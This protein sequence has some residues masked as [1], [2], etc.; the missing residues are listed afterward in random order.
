MNIDEA[1]GARRTVRDFESRPIAR[2]T[3]EAILD[4]GLHAPTHDA[5]DGRRFVLVAD[6]RLREEVA[7]LFHRER[8]R[9]E[10]ALLVDS[11]GV[12]DPQLK[13]MFLDG[14]PKQAA[15]IRTA[16]VLIV[17]CFLQPEPLLAEKGSLHQLNAFAEAWACIENILIA[18]AAVGIGG[19]TKIPSTPQETQQ[20][21]SIL[22]VPESYEIP[23]C[24]ALGYPASDAPRFPPA[25]PPAREVTFLNRWERFA[26]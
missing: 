15:M 4:A 10:L 22:G 1:I 13:A 19:V 17:P 26:D 3:L 9:E 12:E 24:L 18:A 7:L 23:C 11:W 6:P 16:A 21:R 25:L 5:R 14:I 20:L 2:E 8:S